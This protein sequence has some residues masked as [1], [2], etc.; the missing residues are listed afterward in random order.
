MPRSIL[1]LEPE[2]WLAMESTQKKRIS[3]NGRDR[4]QSRN[5]YLYITP[6][7]IG[8]LCFTLLPMLFSLFLSFCKWDIVTGLSSI[9][10]VGLANFQTM[11]HDKKFWK[12]LQVTF[13]YCGMSI[14][15]MQIFSLSIALLLNMR[16]PGMRAFRSVYFLPSIIPAV[17]SSMIMIQILGETGLLNQGLKFFGI[18]GPAWL[19]NTHT[20]L[21]ALVIVGLWGFGNTMIIYLSGLQGVDQGL[22]EAAEIDGAGTMRKF[23]NIT[24]PMLSPTLF[25]NITMSVIGSFQYFTQAYV[26]TEGGPLNSTLFYN[27]YLYTNAYKEYRMG[28]AAALAWVMFVIILILT[29]LVI[30]SS[31]LW[32][33]YQNDDK[34]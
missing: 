17:A 30:K 6:W 5:G 34:I 9:K 7:L 23:W 21:F 28:Y 33:F 27:L 16:I 1:G 26:I 24:I 8:F 4:T 22:Y 20:S 32:V 18:I 2:R 12:A 11:I 31:N 19:K 29:M 14:P 13:T 15:L 25:F 10:F 3:R